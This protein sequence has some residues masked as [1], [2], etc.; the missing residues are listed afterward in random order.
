MPF[1]KHDFFQD[2][3]PHHTHFNFTHLNMSQL[4]IFP[5]EGV[6]HVTLRSLNLPWFL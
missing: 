5:N 2:C 4:Q 3:E 6:T 1:V